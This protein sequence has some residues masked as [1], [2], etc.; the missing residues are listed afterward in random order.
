MKCIIV[1]DQA[2]AQRV[3]K[4]YIQDMGSLELVGTFSDAMQ[5]LSFLNKNKVDLIFLDIHLPKISGLD[6]LKSLTKKPEVILTTAFSEYAVQSYEFD[7]ADYLVKPFSFQRFVRAVSKLDATDKVNTETNNERPAKSTTFFVKSGYEYLKV[8]AEE[9]RFINT[10][11]DYT[12][13]NLK[14]KKHLSTESLQYW[15]EKLGEDFIRVHKSY[16]VN[17]EYVNK[18]AGNIVYLIDAIELPIGRAY[19]EALLSRLSS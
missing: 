14:G 10:D 4:K 16:L 18:V 19:K 1:E 6:F 15:E 12:E 7:V 11:M 9:I 3:L 2:P 5:A 8:N 17:L 13:L